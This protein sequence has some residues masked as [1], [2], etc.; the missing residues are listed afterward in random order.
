M[1]TKLPIAV[2]E[3]GLDSRAAVAFSQA[4][5]R[6]GVSRHVTVHGVQLH[7]LG[8]NLEANDKPVVLLVH[9]FR[10]H[11]HWWDGIAPYLAEDYRVIALD[12]SGMG[13]SDHRGSYPFQYAAAD[14]TGLIEAMELGPVTAIGHS[15]GGV[16]LLKAC[17]DHPQLFKRLINL[18]SYIYFPEETPPNDPGK[19]VRRYYPD[20]ATAMGRYRLVPEQPRFEPAV[21]EHIAR[22]S[23]REESEGW[24]WK[25]DPLIPAGINHEIPA[26]ELLPRVRRPV[27]VVYA[28][29]SAVISASHARE[30][31]ALL[32]FGKGP[33]VMPDAYHHMMIDQPQ[34]LTAL[35]KSLLADGDTT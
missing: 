26:R 30:T 32:P 11:A 23:L 31:V 1:A 18:D 10:G 25:F 15:Y 5:Q 6:P 8:W 34:E 24:C 27:H 4:L 35:L 19:S 14:I 29:G 20:L 33:V 3:G 9:G 13:D 22:H 28:E 2:A 21:L 17:A 16:R 7:Y 12:L